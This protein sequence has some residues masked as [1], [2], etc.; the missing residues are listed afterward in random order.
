MTTNELIL[1][2]ITLFTTGGGLASVISAVNK[3]RQNKIL[4][5]ELETIK[6]I[7]QDKEIEQLQ[8]DVKEI[9][10]TNL[11]IVERMKAKDFIEKFYRKIKRKIDNI[12][13][14][15]KPI[16]PEIKH[17]IYNGQKAFQDFLQTI[18]IE[19]FQLA[20]NELF[21]LV[22]HLL[23]NVKFKIDR[24]KLNIIDPE[25]FLEILE[26]EVI[27]PAI[28]GF[29]IDYN[30]LSELENGVRRRKFA[31]IS[32]KFISQIVENTIN[33]YAKYKSQKFYR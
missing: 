12:L 31:E 23:K 20:D 14:V 3:A 8:K 28:E 32:E 10:E 29:V 7:Q 5:K 25:N 24:T 27:K 11:W 30:Q 2:I 6:D 4:E 15:K 22:V 9:K 18:I 26:T 13:S 19:N 16:N 33:I 17:L 21:E 1:A